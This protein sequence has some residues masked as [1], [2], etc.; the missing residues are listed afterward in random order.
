MKITISLFLLVSFSIFVVQARAQE[1]RQDETIK[2]NTDLVSVPV[3][4]SDRQGRYIPGLKAE[5][6][7]LYQDGIKQ[8]ISFFG[9]EEEPLNVALLLD[10]SRS[11]LDALEL[12]QD[13]AQDFIR[14]LQP[15]DRAMVASFDRTVKAL[16]PLTSDRKRLARAVE[17][18]EIGE[19]FGTVMRDAVLEVVEQYFASVKGRKAI[20]LLTDGKDFGSSISKDE[21]LDKLEESDVM[22]YSVLYDTSFTPMARRRGGGRRGGMGGGRRG[23]VWFPRDRD[24]DER[25]GGVR[26]RERKRN[27]D[28]LDYVE[29]MADVSAGRFY[30]N[31]VTDLKET[32][33]LIADELRK[34]YRLGYYPP[35]TEDDSG[36]HKI[37]VKVDRADVA[38]RSRGS[39]RAKKDG[40]PN[41]YRER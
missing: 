27:E 6:F 2:I 24:R 10:T 22:V 5:D 9:A 23:G 30:Q 11:A 3:V 40:A 31:D 35:D 21:L 4:V 33:A 1:A 13:A 17:Q 37:R 39:Y 19:R 14:L 29:Q 32:F 20:V 38:V 7:S 41:Q 15:A 18:V 36:A 26:D 8:T 16:S 25:G 12:I 34:H 28:A